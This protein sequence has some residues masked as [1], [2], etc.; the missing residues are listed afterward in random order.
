MNPNEENRLY[1]YMQNSQYAQFFNQ[2]HNYN[3][4]IEPP[5][6]R[7]GRPRTNPRGGGE[8]GRGVGRPHR[9]GRGRGNS[10]E[11]DED[12]FDSNTRVTDIQP[13]S[14]R[15][16][17]TNTS[18]Y[19]EDEDLFS[20]DEDIGSRGDGPS[21]DYLYCKFDHEQEATKYLCK[22]IGQSPIHSSFIVE[23]E[24]RSGANSH[25]YYSEYVDRLHDS[26]ELGSNAAANCVEPA[27]SPFDIN[28]MCVDRII[29]H[30]SPDQS[31]NIK[32]EYYNSSIFVSGLPQRQERPFDHFLPFSN[33]FYSQEND[34]F[35]FLDENGIFKNPILNRLTDCASHSNDTEQPEDLTKIELL[36]Q[37]RNTS[38]ND[39]TWEKQSS[40]MSDDHFFC[41]ANYE[42][43]KQL[44]NIYLN[45][46]KPKI[47]NEIP[48]TIP[49][50]IEAAN[51]LVLTDT[52]VELVKRLFEAKIKRANCQ[53]I[54][55]GQSGRVAAI[56]TF[57]Q[58]LHSQYGSNK[59]T[60]I[61]TTE[62]GAEIWKKT[63]KIFSNLYWA[64][65]LQPSP[66]VRNHNLTESNKIDILIT[67]DEMFN[68]DL[69]IQKRIQYDNLII[70][71][72]HGSIAELDILNSDAFTV[73][74]SPSSIYPNLRSIHL[75]S[76]EFH[77]SET[78]IMVNNPA[79]RSIQAWLRRNLKTKSL[80]SVNAPSMQF[81]LQELAL[82]D[83]HPLLVPRIHE[84]LLEERAQSIANIP[85]Q[86]RQ[87]TF[88][89]QFSGK[90]QK[91]YEIIS[92]TPLNLNEAVLVIA[93][94]LSLLRFVQLFLCAY[95][96]PNG[97][98]ISNIK[99][100]TLHPAFQRGVILSNRSIEPPQLRHFHFTRIIFLD[101]PVDFQTEI[102]FVQFMN[103]KPNQQK[104][105]IHL[106]N[107]NSIESELFIKC[108]KHGTFDYRN[109]PKEKI[110]KYIRSACYLSQINPELEQTAEFTLD[111]PADVSI[112]KQKMNSVMSTVKTNSDFWD[113]FFN[114]RAKEKPFW[115][116]K[117]CANFVTLLFQYG[118]NKWDQIATEIEK[119]IDDVISYGKSVLTTIIHQYRY[120]EIGRQNI[121]NALI[122]LEL[123]NNNGYTHEF[124]NDCQYWYLQSEQI[125]P[126]H[127]QTFQVASSS[128]TRMVNNK[129]TTDSFLEL[130]TNLATI[131]AFLSI[132]SRPYIPLRFFVQV[133]NKYTTPDF[134]YTILDNYLKYPNNL[135]KIREEMKI[136]PEIS[137]D[138]FNLMVKQILKTI[139]I[140]V[141]SFVL[142]SIANGTSST[143]FE[144]NVLMK[145]FI[146]VF[147]KGPFIW[148]WT[149]SE[150][151]MVLDILSDFS[152]PLQQDG[153]YDWTEFHSLLSMSTKSTDMIKKYSLHLVEL[154]FAAE[155]NQDVT[156]EPE[157][158]KIDER[159]HP[160]PTIKPNTQASYQ[161]I[162]VPPATQ[163]PIP[164]QQ[165]PQLYQQP[166]YYQQYYQPQVTYPANIIQY[167]QVPIPYSHSPHVVYQYQQMQPIA[168]K[169][170][171]GR[172][173]KD[174]KQVQPNQNQMS[175]VAQQPIYQK[176]REIPKP[177]TPINNY[178]KPDYS[179]VIIAS[180]AMKLQN[181]V[182][183]LFYLRPLSRKP[184]QVV[185]PVSWLPDSW[186]YD[187][188]ISII[189]GICQFGFK[190]IS[191][192]CLIDTSAYANT[193]YFD[194]HIEHSLSEFNA[195][196]SFFSQRIRF[197]LLWNMPI[198][199]HL[200]FTATPIQKISF[201]Y[202][203][204]E[205]PF[206]PIDAEQEEKAKKP[207]KPRGPYKKT[208]LLQ[209]KQ[210]EEALKQQEEKK[211]EE[212]TEPAMQTRSHPKDKSKI[213][214]KK[215]SWISDDEDH[216]KTKS[217]RRMTPIEKESSEIKKKPPVVKEQKEKVVKEKPKPII[218]LPERIITFTY[219]P[220][221]DRIRL[222]FQVK[223]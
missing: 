43:Y 102:D 158:G 195:V 88:I 75:E 152:I 63:I 216:Q 95:Q 147:E 168:Q 35:I 48:L 142:H 83:S 220:T 13:R 161:P 8:R 197:L 1:Q 122:Y 59:P 6:R 55:E 209:Q 131:R 191:N 18:N 200:T 119:P 24:I 34:P 118:L 112:M 103:N 37:W 116:P 203:H 99:R 110:E 183:S 173:R 146:L 57:L 176:L 84:S 185:R 163:M 9:R 199:R 91:L 218:E 127:S 19:R 164:E 202:S 181:L 100:E 128:A 132:H 157:Y 177:P 56:V 53:I 96:M 193:E 85:E 120:E 156:I 167:Q 12:F 23:S 217:K 192:L 36:I 184:P 188:D 171:I 153:E 114:A 139:T 124:D 189:N 130:I 60:V 151:Q 162:H 206:H 215:V 41:I 32:S 46:I 81:L 54:S 98:L 4:A 182:S 30:R 65:Y 136:E 38:P 21:I 115:K 45:K 137:F 82:A 22:W 111:F 10:S 150:T 204:P 49:E 144:E 138:Q 33:P 159:T 16:H 89:S 73:F 2:A 74:T 39:S 40:L 17:I 11:S 15:S 149:D 180:N 169:K 211:V 207:R 104:E 31:S 212:K 44:L 25:K 71:T 47:A 121:A 5:R 105:F 154:L 14:I 42:E 93:E 108:V 123:N 58:I 198:K 64:D 133:N 72:S 97:I 79:C 213:K 145:P 113:T 77:F 80:R 196:G 68:D 101:V 222:H 166:Q 26:G 28:I 174:A 178:S 190:Q 219:R 143:L 7:R 70:D 61:V 3:P 155:K 187:C 175:M 221:S 160:L 117:D 135:T 90:I 210:Q 214:I 29:A 129:Q 52:Q 134:F 106:I 27:N 94:N 126:H 20:E 107:K 50:H 172:P 223:D 62:F 125:P 66:I 140:D 141:Y 186:D 76:T 51:D 67:T 87:M 92:R 179:Y 109:L 194:V 78:V 170:P 165:Q 208:L 69:E 205:K 148:Y 86:T 201:F